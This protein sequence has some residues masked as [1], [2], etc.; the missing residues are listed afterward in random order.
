MLNT[1]T[2]LM[3]SVDDVDMYYL[4]FSEAVNIANYKVICVNVCSAEGGFGWV[5]RFL[6]NLS[7]QVHIDDVISMEVAVPSGVPQCSIIGPL[8][9]LVVVNDLSRDILLFCPMFANNT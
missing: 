7:I 1:V 4:D 6:A 3:D 5:Q 2:L 9:F 8:P